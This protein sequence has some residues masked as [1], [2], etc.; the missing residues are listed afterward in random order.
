[1]PTHKKRKP[2]KKAVKKRKTVSRK[3]TVRRKMVVRRKRR[4]SVS[5]KRKPTRKRRTVRRGQHIKVTHVVAGKRRRRRSHAMVKHTQTRPRRRRV[6]MAG[7]RTRSRSVGR[8][9]GSGLLIAVGIGALAVYLL[10]KGSTTT[11]YPN[12]P[13]LPPLTT[14][15]N[16]QRNQQQDSILQYALAA[17]LGIDAI[18]KLIASLNNSSDT[19]VQNIYDHVNTTGTL[20]ETVY[21]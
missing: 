13:Q 21:V 3:K 19:D 2:A 18:S 11:T 14:T 4:A 9:G 12:Y 10:T 17:S 1:M 8:K 15:S 7:R 20:P 16:Y 5:G 6:V